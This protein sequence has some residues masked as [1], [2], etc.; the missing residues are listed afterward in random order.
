MKR[1]MSGLSLAIWRLEEKV[2]KL[3]T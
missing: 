3:N 1:E 2:A